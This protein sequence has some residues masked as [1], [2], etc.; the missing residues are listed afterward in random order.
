MDDFK[1]DLEFEWDEGNEL[2]NWIRHKVT[3]K[4]AEE[5]FL[6]RSILVGSDEKHSTSEI[7]YLAYGRALGGKCLAVV[8]TKRG[9][10]LRIISARQMN[11]KERN[12]YDKE[13]V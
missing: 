4:E 5:V 11:K 13:K 3:N 6:D 10:K 9:K 12:K 7:R 2:K 1:G 8:F